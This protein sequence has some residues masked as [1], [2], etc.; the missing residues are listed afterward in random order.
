MGPLI[1]RAPSPLHIYRSIRSGLSLRSSH[2]SRLSKK[3]SSDNHIPK[4]VKVGDRAGTEGEE[5]E[6][7]E[8]NHPVSFKEVV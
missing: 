4:N 3:L 1:R 6:M 5:H 7:D 8:I 2:E